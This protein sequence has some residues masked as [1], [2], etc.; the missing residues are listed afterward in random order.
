[1]AGK[2]PSLGD[3][4]RNRQQSGFVGRQGQVVQ[5]LENLGFPA[6]DE[7]RR[8]LFNIHGD[9]GVGKTYLTKQLQ[10]LT[11]GRGALTAYVDETIDDATSAMS[12]IAEEFGRSGARLSEFEKRAAAYR[13]RRHELESDPEAPEGFATFLTK[14]AFIIGFDAARNLPIGGSLLA[15]VDPAAAADQVNR[16]RM[17]LA[18]KFSNHADMKLLLSPA[19]E[20]TPIFVS[21]LNR[22]AADRSI[23]LFFDTYERTGLVL[24]RWLRGLY[25]EHYG[26]LPETLITSISGQNPLNPNLWGEYLPVIADISLEPFSEAEA[27]QF[28]GS[29][30]IHD[31]STIQ[32]ILTLSGRLPMWLATLAESRPSDAA[33]IGDPAGD[34][35]ERFLKWEDDP[36]KRSIAMTA[37]LPRVLNQDMLTAIA[38]S[39]KAR[40]LFSWL[41]GL[42]FVT[43][44]AG[45]WAYHEVVRAAMLRLQLAQAPSE[46]RSNQVTLA[47]AN[48]R[49]ARDAAGGTDKDWTNPNWIDHTREEIYH[50]LCA[51]PT[52]NLPKALASAVEAAEHN[53]T[54]A[55]QWAGLIVDAGRDTD[56]PTLSHWGQRLR[57][58]IHDSD[59]TQYFTYLIN[60]AHLG[61]DTLTIALEE[62]GECHRI[63]GRYNQALADYSRAVELDP[64]Q[65]WAIGSRGQTYQAMERYDEALADYTRAIELDPSQAWAIASRG[66][67]YQLMGRYDEALA[68][69]TR[70]IE[71][72]PSQ[73]WAFISRGPI[74]EL[75]GRYDE[76]L[77]DYTRAI[78][79]DPSQAWAIGGRGQ[80]YQAME[81]YDEAL[82]DYTRAIE[83]D[84]S[85]EWAIAERGETYR[86]MG[87]YD[88]ALADYTRAIELDPSDAVVIAERGETYRLMGRYDEA[89]ADYTRAI[90]LDPTTDPREGSRRRR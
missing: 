43:R 41:C 55:R 4:I 11:I 82:A 9:A 79:L 35:V 59:L 56:N 68:D 28:L 58:G 45:S 62:R 30:D 78:E 32:V 83:L 3:H 42:P 90:K 85:D 27:R 53:T 89:L 23:A 87:R 73:A 26:G 47:Q 14:T 72:D 86:L 67:T 61:N 54:R 31:E 1:M 6:D 37:A 19:D 60:D 8:F 81:R 52:N 48:G 25:A 29:K 13:Q 7:R 20:L 65:A 16:A 2:R 77:A 46:W 12:V 63:A 36:A 17:Y 69:Y 88:E 40:E 71:L 50:L 38:P 21:E 24:D 22:V 76:A 64:S 75:M 34:A 80:T 18:R 15:P 51:D 84:P 66:E 49:W 74:Y 39:D 44:R 10:L 33:D 57:D 5:Y 70:A